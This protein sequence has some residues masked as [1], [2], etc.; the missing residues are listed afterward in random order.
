MQTM[1]GVNVT[2]NSI[3]N[4]IKQDNLKQYYLYPLN[5]ILSITEINNLQPSIFY[6]ESSINNLVTNRSVLNV[7]NG[8]LIIGSQVYELPGG[9][10]LLITERVG[11]VEIHEYYNVDLELKEGSK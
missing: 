8:D 5:D 9:E 11:K 2:G 7:G 1:I 10:D 3:R 4:F 6:S